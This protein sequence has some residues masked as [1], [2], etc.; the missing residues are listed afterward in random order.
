MIGLSGLITPSLDEMVHVAKEMKRLQFEVPLLIGGATTSPRTHAVKIDPEYAGPVAYVKDAS[1]AV[2]VCQSLVDARVARELTSAL[3]RDHAERREQHRGRKVKAPALTL[4]QARAK[5]R[6]AATGRRTGRPCRASR[7]AHFRRTCRSTPAALHRL[8]AVFQR[9]GIRGRFPD[10]LTDPVVGEAASNLYAD[11]RR[12]LRADDRRALGAGARGRSDSSR[13]TR[14][15]TTSRF[16]PTNPS[17]GR[18]TG[19]TP[20]PAEAEAE[21]TAALSPRGFRAPRD[22][23]IADWIG[24]FAVTTGLGIEEGARVRG[25][26]DDYNSIMVKALADRLPR[27]SPSACTSACGAK[28]WGYCARGAAHERRADPRAYRGIR[29]APGLSGLSRSHGEGGALA[30]AR[31]RAQ[32][33]HRPLTESYAMHPRRRGQRLV[34]S[35]TR[36][37]GVLSPSAPSIATRSPDYARRKRMSLADAERWL[38]PLIGNRSSADALDSARR[39]SPPGREIAQV[40]PERGR[41]ARIEAADRTLPEE[42]RSARPSTFQPTDGPRQLAV[43]SENLASDAEVSTVILQ[44]L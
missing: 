14:S 2:G 31:S 9:V 27:R 6:S 23:G 19:C 21:R 7:R 28:F 20:A 10:V 38:A 25:A 35:R 26:H 15:T 44:F 5:P 16:T 34:F 1:R 17:R 29:P 39:R 40:G 42:P 36:T 18:C 8:D 3:K 12:V 30:P 41:R 13:R 33:R 4:E 11:A 24:G 32:C 43:R 37:F 22:S